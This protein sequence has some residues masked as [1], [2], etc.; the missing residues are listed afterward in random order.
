MTPG[1]DEPLYILP[2]DH[3]HSYGSEVFGF[4]EPMSP[5]QIAEVAASKQVIYA[6]YKRALATGAPKER[7]GIL[8][9]EE[10]GAAIL[11]DA[12]RNGYITAMS[13]EKSG[14][15]EFDFEYGEDFARHID[16]FDPTF[17][18]VLVRYNPEGDAASNQRQTARLKRLSDYLHKNHRLFMFELLV[19]P[20]K[21]Q[22]EKLQDKQAYDRQLRPALM[23]RA[24]RDMQD[25]GVEPDVWKIEGLDR[26]EDCE[27]MVAVARRDGR[28]QVG[29]IILGRGENAQKVIEWLQTAASVP[30]FIGF[31]VG[32][33]SF[34]QSI[35]DLH[36][37][38]ITPD[39]AAEEIAKRFH[40][41][42]D[43]FEKAR[44]H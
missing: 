21:A 12:K 33:S 2:F 20:E 1:Y 18:K 30:G 10:F 32:R 11:R 25:A 31:A 23:E 17:T 8:V 13:T 37:K 29:C 35:V 34:L 5:D 39:A 6:G 36:A 16:E 40:E 44:S 3:R 41:W 19:P 22:L 24:I 7:T 38:R 4:H 28:G 9:D 14:Q 42:I 43:V 15:H 27:K 26:R